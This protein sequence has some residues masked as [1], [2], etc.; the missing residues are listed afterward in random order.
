MKEYSKL[1]ISFE[2]HV[3]VVAMA[4]EPVNALD[5]ELVAQIGEAFDELKVNKDVWCVV[6]CSD[7]KLFAAGADLK[8]L[9]KADRFGNMN[10]SITMQETFLKIENF[11]HPVIAAV[12]GGCFGGALEMALSC[13]LR[14]FDTKTKVGLPEASLGICPGAGGAQRL[15]KLIGIGAAKRMIFSGEIIRGEEA[16]RLGICEYLAE[17]GQLREKAMEIAGKI[18]AMAPI[19]VATDK[20][21][22]NYSLDHTIAEGLDYERLIASDV[23]CTEDKNEGINAF[24]E[25]RTAIFQN[26]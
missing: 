24:F 6:L 16:Y 5:T 13:D 2:G 10:T 1:H 7:M 8:A 9:L 3:A 17:E 25:K 18:C 14:I 26:K 4:N 19:A 22:V 21:M 15:P 12:N 11:P 23:F 20:I